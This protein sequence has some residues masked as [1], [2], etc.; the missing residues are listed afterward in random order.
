MNN[1]NQQR[2]L[3]TLALIA[4]ILSIWL[5]QPGCATFVDSE[6]A[7][8]KQSQDSSV[9]FRFGLARMIERNGSLADARVAYREIIAS[10]PK[11]VP[12]L[13]RLGVVSIQLEDLDSAISYLSDAVDCG[14]P[15]SDLLGDIGYAYF[16]NGEIDKAESYMRD[17]VTLAPENVRLLNNLAMIV[18]HQGHL[19]ESLSL[20]RQ[21]NS[22]PEAQANMAFVLSSLGKLEAA[23]EH[24]HR[25]LERDPHLKKAAHGLSEFYRL[26]DKNSPTTPVSD[27]LATSSRRD[28]AVSKVDFVDPPAD[29]SQ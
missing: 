10:D 13:H 6:K 21:G 15:S 1:P 18:G 2:Q 25:A 23:K 14:K 9:D 29:E 22:E 16:L 27:H 17:A 7:L 28:R 26:S 3:T 8:L 20:F 4:P 19:D 24:Y 5:L 12:T 11:H